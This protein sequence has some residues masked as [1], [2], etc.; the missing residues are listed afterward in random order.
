MACTLRLAYPY[1]GSGR[2]LVADAWFGS[3][4]TAEWVVEQLGLYVILAVKTGC[5]GYPKKM[6]KEA[7]EGE[8]GSYKC[9]SIDVQLDT[10]VCTFYASGFMDKKPLLLVANCGTTFFEQAVTRYRRKFEG[11]ALRRSQY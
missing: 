4:N 2:T 3:C 9:Y 8:R 1:R 11:G 7:I 10:G 5:A 6:L